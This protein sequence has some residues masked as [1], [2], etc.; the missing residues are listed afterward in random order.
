MKEIARSL[1]SVIQKDKKSIDEISSKQDV[2]I[3]NTNKEVE[4]LQKINS[5]V[6]VGFCYKIIMA[7]TAL[8]VFVFMIVF[9]RL[10]PNRRHVLL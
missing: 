10:F 1:S 6:M 7:V 3:N 4:N 8:G 9:I 5:V 2:N